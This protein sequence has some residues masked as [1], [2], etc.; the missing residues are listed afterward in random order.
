MDCLDDPVIKTAYKN[1][2]LDEN[3][4]TGHTDNDQIQKK[5][6][7]ATRKAWEASIIPVKLLAMNVVMIYM[8]AGGIFGFII[9]GY[10][11]ISAIRVL[12]GVNKTFDDLQKSIGVPVNTRLQ[13]LTYITTASILL[14]YFIY[15]CAKMGFLPLN[16][17][18]VFGPS[19]L[20]GLPLDDDV[21]LILN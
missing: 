7:L 19:R 2:K 21:L 1:E 11:L 8:T 5:K 17:V 15:Q 20:G 6:Q 16:T 4:V 3:V 14:A 10:A 18:D 9:L 12:V 13:R